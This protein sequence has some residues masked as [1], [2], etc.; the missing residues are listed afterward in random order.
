MDKNSNYQ[1]TYQQQAKIFLMNGYFSC[2]QRILYNCIVFV[3]LAANLI[4]GTIIHEQLI[5]SRIIYERS[6]QFI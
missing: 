4:E 2:I 5:T 3:T 6:K 1:L